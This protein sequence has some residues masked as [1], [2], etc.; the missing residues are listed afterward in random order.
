MVNVLNVDEMLESKQPE[1]KTILGCL[2]FPNKHQ[3]KLIFLR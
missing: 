1:I 2:K 3:R